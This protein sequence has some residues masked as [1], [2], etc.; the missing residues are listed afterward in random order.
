MKE[1]NNEKEKEEK[2]NYLIKE[3]MDKN[4]DTEKFTD[5]ISKLK[6]NGDNVDNWTFDELICY[7]LLLSYLNN[8][9]YSINS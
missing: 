3:I 4:Y 9:K 7:F 8:N 2:Q 1:N 5:Y 6:E